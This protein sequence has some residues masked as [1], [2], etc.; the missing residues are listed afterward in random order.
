MEWYAVVMIVL[1]AVSSGAQIATIG[2]R[3]DPITPG[4]ALAGLVTNGLFI[5]AIVTL[6]N[7]AC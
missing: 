3:R 2:R 1:L 6:S 7:S 4:L 5:W